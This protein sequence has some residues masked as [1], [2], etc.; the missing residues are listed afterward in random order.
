VQLPRFLIS[1]FVASTALFTSQIS[2][3][4]ILKGETAGVGDP[5]HTMFVAFSNQAAKADVQIQ[6]NAGQTLTKSMLKG[7]KGEIDFFSSV[8]SLV[9]LMAGQKK[10]YEKVEDAAELS[11]NLRAILGFKAGAY[12]PVTLSGSG[13]ETWED[14]KGKSVFT[15]PPAGSASA[16]SETLIKIITGFEAGSDYTAVRLSWGEGYTALADGKIDMMVRPAEVGSANIER[17]GLSGE[18]RILSIP[19]DALESEAMRALFGRPG[20]G[21][22]QFD[23]G[24]YKGQLTDGQINALGFTQFVGTHASVSD[25]VVYAATKAFWENLSEVHAT[26]FFLQAVTPETAFTSVWNRDTRFDSALVRQ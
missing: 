3:A 15:G 16:T 9:T 17:Y 21:M 25:D 22:L 19:D 11:K 6:V 7:A 2:N 23:G 12:H 24:I 20:R 1:A 14:I 5:V 8:P 4:E 10:M 26:A 18:F 13:I